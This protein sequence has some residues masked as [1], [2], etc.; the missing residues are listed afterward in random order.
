[1]PESYVPAQPAIELYPN[2]VYGDLHN[3]H[4]CAVKT[5]VAV[6]DPRCCPHPCRCCKPGGCVYIQI[7]VPPRGPFKYEVK[8]RDYSKIEYDYGDYEV[9]ITSKRGLVY[10]DYDD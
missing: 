2:V 10:V 5:I 4:P 6:K 9:E 1:V 8:R 3:I 7:C